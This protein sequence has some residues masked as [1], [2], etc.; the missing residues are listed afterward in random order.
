MLANSTA[1]AKKWKWQLKK[2]LKMKIIKKK[3]KPH[4]I[5]K[6]TESMKKLNQEKNE[7]R[8]KW[9]Q[10]ARAERGGDTSQVLLN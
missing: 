2:N 5:T 3:L 7:I 6:G 10:L 1:K 8:I 4:E 9:Y